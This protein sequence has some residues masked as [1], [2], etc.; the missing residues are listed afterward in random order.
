VNIA[1]GR[2]P[3]GAKSPCQDVR[4]TPNHE[5]GMLTSTLSTLDGADTHGFGNVEAG[6]EIG[7]LPF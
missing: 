7:P 3:W 6:S 1:I 2:R 4:A 5:Y